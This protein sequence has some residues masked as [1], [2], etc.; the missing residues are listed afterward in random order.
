MLAAGYLRYITTKL[1]FKEIMMEIQNNN[2]NVDDNLNKAFQAFRS[3]ITTYLAHAGQWT[4]IRQQNQKI[5]FDI[6]D[7]RSSLIERLETV[8]KSCQNQY[9]QRSY[10]YL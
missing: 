1:F 8:I 6:E 9:Q 10:S 2:P 3:E 7:R 4:A 5:L